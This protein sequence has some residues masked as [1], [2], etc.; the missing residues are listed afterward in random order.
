[1]IAVVR[2]VSR[3]IARLAVSAAAATRAVALATRAGS[4][5]IAISVTVAIA[6]SLLLASSLLLL[7][8]LLLVGGIISTQLSASLSTC[9]AMTRAQREQSANGVR[10]SK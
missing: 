1:M 5:A 6:L 8:L 3:S 2:A 10:Q 9:R 4:I 7:L